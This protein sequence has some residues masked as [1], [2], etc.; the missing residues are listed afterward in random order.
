[1]RRQSL[2]GRTIILGKYDEATALLVIDGWRKVLSADGRD[3]ARSHYRGGALEEEL[4]EIDDVPNG[5]AVEG[6]ADDRHETPD[7]VRHGVIANLVDDV[8]RVRVGNLR[9]RCGEIVV[10][11]VRKNDPEAVSDESVQH[12]ENAG[13]VHRHAYK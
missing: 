6:E 8:A 9:T 1:M 13:C 3:G 2:A 10:L 12:E 5:E 4:A 11:A 7:E